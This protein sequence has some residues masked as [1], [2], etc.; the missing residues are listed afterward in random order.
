MHLNLMGAAKSELDAC[1]PELVKQAS[2]LVIGFNLPGLLKDAQVF[3]DFVDV[4][5]KD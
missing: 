1:F 3:I 4:N 5:D 2:F